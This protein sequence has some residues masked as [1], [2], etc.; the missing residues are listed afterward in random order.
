[1]VYVL[2][3][4]VLAEKIALSDSFLMLLIAF[5]AFAVVRQSTHI[6]AYSCDIAKHSR[7]G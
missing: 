3:L 2:K 4:A 6:D 5:C 1:M 7:D